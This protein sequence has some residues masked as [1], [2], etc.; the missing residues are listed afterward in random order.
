MHHRH[1]G[2]SGLKVSEIALGS[3]LTLGGYVQ[4]DDARS[5]VR[6]AF[7]LGINLFDT[8]NEYAAGE[9]ERVLGRALRDLPRSEVVVATKA[10][11]PMGPGPNERGLSRKALFEQCDASLRR[12][13]LDY[14][15]L[16]QCHRFDPETPLE[17]T[18]RALDDLVSSGRVLYAGVSEWPAVQL[19]R[20]R[21]LQQALNLRR[22]VSDQPEYSMLVRDIE[23][24]VLP[25]SERL[26]IGL[27]AY[28]PLAQGTLTGRYTTADPRPRGTRASDPE[29]GEWMQD[30]LTDRVLSAVERLGEVARE[31]G[32]TT[33]QLALAWVL[34]HRSV[35][36]VIVGAS[37]PE[38]LDETTGAAG[39]TLAP[40]T[41][42]A[43]ERILAEIGA[44]G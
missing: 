43:I 29:A 11:F 35:S 2:A 31:A 34:R 4:A 44:P 18:L 20:A 28:S 14:V 17:E 10:F 42:A 21:E 3:W 12:L 33:S 24:D 8:A 26:G 7:D 16:L 41:L 40:E 25:T 6:H 38:Q 5:L 37:R 1:L 15:D 23:A 39:V 19:E 13:E 9:A 32:L 30:F 22:L 36:A 27:L